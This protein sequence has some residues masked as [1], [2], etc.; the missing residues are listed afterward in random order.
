MLKQNTQPGNK[1]VLFLAILLLIGACRLVQPTPKQENGAPLTVAPAVPRQEIPPTKP[2]M[3]AN[4]GE[5][6]KQTAVA[7]KLAAHVESV[8]YAQG[9]VEK[10]VLP[11]CFDF[12]AGVASAP[13]DPACD[14][15]FLPGAPD[16]GTIEVF[17]IESAHLAYGGVFPQ[18]PT[19]A[20]CGGSQA[21][22]NEREIVA[23]MAS[24][25]VCYQTGE[26]R[27]GYLHFTGADLEQTYTLAFDWLTFAN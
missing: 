20:E 16:S 18:A 6:V 12:D 19:K 1:V 4:P 2:P 23:P 10:F 9:T 13:P 25:Y 7:E 8:A 24:M 15:N 11:G 14:F 27:L 5:A 26:G 21:F 17:P 22:S 3:D